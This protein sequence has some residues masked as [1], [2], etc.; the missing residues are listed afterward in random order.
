MNRATYRILVPTAMS[1]LIAAGPV[2]LADDDEE[3]DLA[4]VPANVMAAAEAAVPGI[5][6]TEAEVEKKKGEMVYELEGEADGVEYEIKVN[7]DGTVR[8]VKEDD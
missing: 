4:D 8:K 6:I 3:I 7:A 5:R 1:L 2:A